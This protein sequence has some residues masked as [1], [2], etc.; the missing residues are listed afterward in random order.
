MMKRKRKRVVF[1]GGKLINNVSALAAVKPMG[2]F[3]VKKG[4]SIE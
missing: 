2:G 4:I 1:R 3:R